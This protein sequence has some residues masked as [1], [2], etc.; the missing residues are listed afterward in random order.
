MTSK[1]ILNFWPSGYAAVVTGHFR[2]GLYKGGGSDTKVC[3]FSWA[4]KWMVVSMHV[5]CKA[6]TARRHVKGATFETCRKLRG[7]MSCVVNNNRKSVLEY[8]RFRGSPSAAPCCGP[9][10][11]LSIRKA[12]GRACDAAIGTPLAENATSSM[13]ADALL[14]IPADGCGSSQF[15]ACSHR[16]LHPALSC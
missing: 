10:H 14:D 4:D 9:H 5:Q 2:K 16:C 13:R 8:H 6:F 1:R 15:C 3:W 7:M 12:T 11:L